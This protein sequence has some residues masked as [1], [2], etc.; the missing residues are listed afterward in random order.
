[1]VDLKSFPSNTLF[2]VL[3][4]WDSYLKHVDLDVSETETRPTRARKLRGPSI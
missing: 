4:E 3:E 1:M 2:E